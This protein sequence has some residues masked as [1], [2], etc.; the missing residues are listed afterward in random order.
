MFRRAFISC[1]FLLSLTG[2]HGQ[3]N[4]TT[5]RSLLERQEAI[6]RLQPDEEQ[7]PTG[8]SQCGE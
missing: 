4:L 7:Q 6:S 3:E 2:I 8:V 1:L 5:S